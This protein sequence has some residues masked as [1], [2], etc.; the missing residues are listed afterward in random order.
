MK[1]VIK[2]KLDPKSVADA[3]TELRMYKEELERRVRLLIETLVDRG[4]EIARAKVIEYDA[5]LNGDM[6]DSINGFMAGDIGY[7]RV[8]SNYALFVE[9]G[10]GPAGAKRPHPLGGNYKPTG[11]FTAADG[12]PMDEIYGWTPIEAD[13]GEIIYFTTGQPSKPFMYETAMQLRELLPEIAM[14]VFA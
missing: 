4:A 14:E 1:K 3:I 5:I 8:D 9:F 12:K 11:W 7:I 2:V 13:D 6:L 10:T